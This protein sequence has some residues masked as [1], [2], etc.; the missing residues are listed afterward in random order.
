MASYDEVYQTLKGMGDKFK[1]SL[2]KQIPLDKFM[3]SLTFAI[4]SNPDLIKAERNSLYRACLQAA[5]EGLL[6]DGKEAALVVFNKN[7]GT[8]QNKKYV[9]QV[10]FMPMMAGILKKMRNSGEIK[11]LTTNVVYEED[12]FNYWV[13]SDGPQLEHKPKIFGERGKPIGVYALAV[14]KDEARYID[15]MEHKDIEKIRS[16]SRSKDS[17]PW[18]DW[19]EEMAKKSVIRRICKILPSSTDLDNIIRADDDFYDL[20][21]DTDSTDSEPAAT[22]E[23]PQV[24][25]NPKQSQGLATAISQSTTPETAPPP[26]PKQE[27]PNEA[28]KPKPQPEV[29]IPI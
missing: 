7:V 9:K 26:E 28:P 10:Q 2:P 19:W 11:S 12:V 20:E 17:G 1:E 6:P 23:T 24:E 5:Q 13:N 21:A 16:C 27:L 18:K 4:V 14:T 29:E 22:E 3:R 15:I 25:A 8:K